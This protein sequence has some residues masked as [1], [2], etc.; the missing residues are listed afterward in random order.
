[1]T[2]LVDTAAAA[3]RAA[4]ELRARIEGVSDKALHTAL[5]R[6]IGEEHGQPSNRIE[7]RRRARQA[8]ENATALLRSE[9][10]YDYDV[11]PDIGDGD[12]PIPIVRIT[13]GPRTLIAPPTIVWNGKAPSK[14]AQDGAVAAMKLKV[15]APA[16]AADVLAAQGRLV[17]ALQLDGYADAKA[18]PFAPVVDH[19]DHTLHAVFTLTAGGLVHLDSIKISGK[20]RTKPKFITGLAPWKSGDVYK[21][22][23]LAEL[24]RRLLDAGVYDSVTVALAP[25]VDQDGLRPVLVNVSDRTKHSL[26][27]GLG[28]ST[29]EGPLVDSTWSTFNIFHSADT[30]AVYAKAQTIDSRLG[31]SLSLPDF[32]GP[33]QTLKFGPDIF[34]DVTNAYTTTGAEF[35]IDLTQRYGK[36]SFFTRGVSFVASRI[37]DHE[38]GHLDIFAMRPLAEYSLDRTD[39]PLNAHT[40]WKWDTRVEPIG[41]FGQETLFYLKAQ[42]QLSRYWSFGSDPATTLAI[43]A[44]AGS[45]IGGKIPQVPASDRFFAG[46]GGTVRGY[47]YQNVGPHYA[48][49]TPQ[50]GLSLVDGSVELRR[51]LYGPFGGVL[52]LDSGAVGSFDTPDFTHI[53]SSVG[54]GF[55]YDLGFAPLRADFAFPLNRL[56][57]ASQPPLEVYLSLGQSF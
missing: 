5:D 12:Q 53:A 37:D 13:L 2:L 11:E 43:R 49:N 21:P 18:E 4:T 30:L 50:G 1:M 8:A 15:G 27:L 20:T 6:A 48:D 28:Y 46:G 31:V 9:G 10:Y 54:V 51:N 23:D 40:G 25:D 32:W 33:S 39:N 56:S 7:A 55:R 16:R 34:N 14:V 35:V 3:G 36:T 45:I 17:A 22:F 44:Q 47:E 38:L 24:E 26:S 52:F 42:T 57:G 29:T 19:A 41:I